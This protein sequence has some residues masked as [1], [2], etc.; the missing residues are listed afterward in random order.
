MRIMIDKLP[1]EVIFHIGH[2]LTEEERGRL[3]QVF[4]KIEKIYKTKYALYK[5]LRPIKYVNF[6][7]KK[8]QTLKKTFFKNIDKCR[9][10]HYSLNT[11]VIQG[12]LH[13]PFEL[14][15]WYTYKTP[16]IR[17]TLYNDIRGQFHYG[18]MYGCWTRNL[19]RYVHRRNQPPYSKDHTD[20]YEFKD[21]KPMLHRIY[22]WENTL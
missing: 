15:I 22:P 18:D 17:C 8:L 5:Y 13:G 6:S 14:K 3:C 7:A 21:D 16:T 9:L 4:L 10:D 1:I 19:Q 11:R 20:D 2:F 12:E